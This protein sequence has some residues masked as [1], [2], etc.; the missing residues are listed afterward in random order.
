MGLLQN[1]VEEVKTLKEAQQ[2]LQELPALKPQVRTPW[3]PSLLFQGGFAP[4]HQT[5]PK[6]PPRP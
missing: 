5:W 2:K 3:G 1:L 4:A 6:D